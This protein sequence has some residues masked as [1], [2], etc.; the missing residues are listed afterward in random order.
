[1]KPFSLFPSPPWLMEEGRKDVVMFF[2][3]SNPYF[4]PIDT[5]RRRS[6]SCSTMPPKKGKKGGKGAKKAGRKWSE[7]CEMHDG[8][9]WYGVFRN[10]KRCLQLLFLCVRC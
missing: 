9:V 4:G 5:D 3:I 8:V 2:L 6:T 1:M 7:L 10:K